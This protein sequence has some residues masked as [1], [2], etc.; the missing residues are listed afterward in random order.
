MVPEDWMAQASCRGKPTAMFFPRSDDGA[1]E[2]RALCAS[3]PVA[4][5]CLEYALNNKQAPVGIWGGTDE[6]E[7]ARIRKLR[8]ASAAA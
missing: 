2:A 6:R 8:R 5:Q 7:R 4:A 1:A 3:C